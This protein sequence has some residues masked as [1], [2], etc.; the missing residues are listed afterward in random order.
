MIR[1]H[2]AGRCPFTSSDRPCLEHCSF[3]SQPSPDSHIFCP[4]S[5]RRWYS[6]TTA[7]SSACARPGK[8]LVCQNHSCDGRAGLPAPRG[9]LSCVTKGAGF[10]PGRVAA[11][12]TEDRELRVVSPRSSWWQAQ[13]TNNGVSDLGTRRLDFRPGQR[14]PPGQEAGTLW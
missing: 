5:P 10:G 7:S 13:R 14:A 6:L 9:V 2:P 8:G 1:G 12:G 4:H 3:R 11:R